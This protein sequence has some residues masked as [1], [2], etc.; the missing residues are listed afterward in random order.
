MQ[1]KLAIDG[2]VPVRDTLLQA[3]YLGA[4]LIDEREIEA[5]TQVLK[6]HSPFRYYGPDMQYAVKRF[7]TNL[8]AR[9]QATYALGVSS[10][11]ASLV[12]AL[13]ACGVGAGD[14]VIVPAVSFIATAGA[15]VCAGAVPLFAD[16]DDS[17]NIAPGEITRLANATTKA[18]ICVPLIGN[19][20]EMNALCAEAKAKGLLVIEDVAQSMGVTYDGRCAGTIGDIGCFSLQINKLITTGEGGAILTNNA[21]LYE[22]ACRYHDQGMFR[23]KEGFLKASEDGDLLI[24]Q[25]YRMSELTGAVACVQLERL[26]GIIDACRA[27]YERI[28]SQIQLCPGVQFRRLV[29]EEEQ[30]G[31]AVML[32]LPTVELAGRFNA[33][34]M[35]ENI[36]CYSLYNGQPLYLNPQILLQKTAEASNFPFNQIHPPVR[37]APGMCPVAEDLMARNAMIPIS[38]TYTEQDCADIAAAV[39]KVLAALVSGV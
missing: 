33:A 4:S 20:C 31:T 3:N 39:N 22:R 17:L 27:V 26:D 16:V 35:A 1:T 10:C 32:F 29:R 9:F 11:T 18:I 36:T 15:V 7:E 30:L 34:M 21:R 12:V 14:T 2:G 25:N 5:V 24:G 23:E 38:P 37:Y 19:P 6:A 13:K 28:V 8:R